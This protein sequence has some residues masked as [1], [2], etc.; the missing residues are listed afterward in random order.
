[1]TS[2]QSTNDIAESSR[3]A[4]RETLDSIEY[5]LWTLNQDTTQLVGTVSTA[6]VKHGSRISQLYRLAG[7]IYLERVLKPSPTNGRLERWSAEAFDILRQLDIC[8]RPFPLFF[9]ACEATTD[10]EREVVIS[11]LKRTHKRSNQ[12][13]LHLIEHMIQSMWVQNDLVS[14]MGERNYV[15][16]LNTTMSSSQLLPTLA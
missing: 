6:E 8:E 4:E 5:D 3:F 10:E 7:L 12:R 14:D 13:R 16:A 9:V 2:I 11:L 15:D 1:M